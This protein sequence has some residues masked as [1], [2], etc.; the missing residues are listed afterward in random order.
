MLM[1]EHW[2]KLAVF[3]AVVFLFCRLFVAENLGVFLA[4][5]AVLGLGVYAALLVELPQLGSG[6]GSAHSY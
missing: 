1:H 6:E 5:A 2:V 4:G 3:L